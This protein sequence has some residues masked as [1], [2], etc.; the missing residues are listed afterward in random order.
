MHF[1]RSTV[2][3][4]DDTTGLLPAIAPAVTAQHDCAAGSR[5]KCESFHHNHLNNNIHRHLRFSLPSLS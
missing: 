1:D 3:M 5:F 2:E 4:E